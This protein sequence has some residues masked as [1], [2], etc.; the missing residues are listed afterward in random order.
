MKRCGL[1]AKMETRQVKMTNPA[2]KL[3]GQM[4][5]KTVKRLSSNSLAFGNQTIVSHLL[6]MVK[7]CTMEH[8]NPQVTALLM[9]LYYC[10]SV[11]QHFTLIQLPLTVPHFLQSTTRAY[12]CRTGSSERVVTESF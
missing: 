1:A 11:L 2:L 6:H 7:V 5:C 3:L 10:P 8:S 12:F 4:E 9:K